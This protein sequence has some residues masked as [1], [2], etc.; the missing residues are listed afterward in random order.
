MTIQT[1]TITQTGT[2]PSSFFET[3]P[4]IAPDAIFALTAEYN[5]DTF[6][7]KVNLG[8]GTYRDEN[9]QPWVLPS[10]RKSR[11]L[12]VEQG[13]NHEYLPILGLQAFRLEASKMALGSGLYEKIQS[14]LATCQGLSGTGSLHLAGLLLRSCRAP[15]PKIYIP[16]PTWSNHHQVFSS[17]G[18]TCESFGYYDDA[19][20]NIDID[21]YYSALKRAEPGSVVILHACAHNPTGCDPSKEQWKEVG[22]IVKEKGLFPLFD[23]AYLGFNSGNIDD[24]AFA[25]RYFVDELDLEAGVCLSFAKNMGLYGE[26]TG[27]LFFVARTDKAATNTQSVLEMLQR[28]EVSNPPAYGAKIA[29]TILAEQ[30]LKAL[31]YRDL[32]TMSG[33]IR[34][35]RRALYDSLNSNGAPG[36]WD[37][38]IRQSGMFGFLGLAPDVV[39]KLKVQYHIYM[40]ANSRVSIAGLND[41]NVDYVGRSIAE[42]LKS[43]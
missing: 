17:L 21:S 38:L 7:Q 32:E 40:A 3:A 10:V 43:N 27:C 25:I 42:C 26:R 24:D 12:L 28:S 22:R 15:L 31:W 8:Q 6:P 39:Q 1:N 35:M 34:A 18:F 19:Q 37:H 5:A 4:Y 36:N 9:G 11:E 20:K 30:E 13:L 2:V 41:G 29:A 14:R 23:A 16:S 33:R